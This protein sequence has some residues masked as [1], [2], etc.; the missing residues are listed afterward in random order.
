M[1]TLEAYYGTPQQS[2]SIILT[3]LFDNHNYG[4]RSPSTTDRYDT[5]VILAPRHT[6]GS[7]F[8]FGHQSSLELLLWHEFSHSFVNPLSEIYVDKLFESR[9]LAIPIDQQMR[10]MNYP[11]WITIVNEHVVRAITT[12][13]AY[14]ERGQVLGDAE[15]EKE[16]NRGFIYLDAILEQLALYETSRTQYPTFADFYPQIVATFDALALDYLG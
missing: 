7:G 16:K 5:F 1:A 4:I 13:L 14:Q 3:F 6:A 8:A 12:R 10:N 15:R 2:Y 11:N 9:L